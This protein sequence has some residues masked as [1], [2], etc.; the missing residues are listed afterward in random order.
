VDEVADELGLVKETLAY[1]LVGRGAELDR[2][3]ALDVGVTALVD[4]AKATDRSLLGKRWVDSGAPARRLG[5][6]D[7]DE[8]EDEEGVGMKMK[9][10]RA[11]VRSRG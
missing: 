11:G 5:R 3:R 6:G 9:M 7:E 10:R 1:L 8:D 4:D 2:D